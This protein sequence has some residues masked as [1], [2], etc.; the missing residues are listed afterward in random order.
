M[1]SAAQIAE[2]HEKG[3]VVP[4]YRLGADVLDAIR[5]DHDRLLASHP[6]FRDNCPALLSY[7][8]AFLNYQTRAQVSLLPATAAFWTWR[9]N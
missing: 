7:D 2:Y 5:R 1:L 8:L 6:D 4:D 3:Y 9:N